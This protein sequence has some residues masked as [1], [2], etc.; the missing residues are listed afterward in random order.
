ML[1]FCFGLKVVEVVLSV[2]QGVLYS[3]L[4]FWGLQW[5]AGL[6]AQ[7]VHGMSCLGT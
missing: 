1:V 4:A 2:S 7:M 3:L 6:P 5:A